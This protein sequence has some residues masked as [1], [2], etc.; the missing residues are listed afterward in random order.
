MRL[1]S[2]TSSKVYSTDESFQ[3]KEFDVLELAFDETNE[4]GVCPLSLQKVFYSF[5]KNEKILKQMYLRFY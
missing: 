5:R 3:M 2:G 4:D 1:I